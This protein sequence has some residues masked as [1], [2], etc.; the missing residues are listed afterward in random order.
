[1]HYLKDDGS[2][3]SKGSKEHYPR[4]G[5]LKAHSKGNEG[6]KEH[7]KGGRIRKHTTQK[8]MVKHRYINVESN[9]LWSIC[10][11]T[12]LRNI[13]PHFLQWSLS[14]LKSLSLGSKLWWPSCSRLLE[15]HLV[16][17]TS[18]KGLISS[19]FYPPTFISRVVNS[20]PHFIFLERE[21]WSQ[22]YYAFLDCPPA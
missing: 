22:P 20:T 13:G 5:G 6:L 4:D 17:L 19:Y 16:I 11:Y 7:S 10:M 21:S 12:Y 8:I 2:K 3:G 14:F 15:S 18:E 9:A 1:M